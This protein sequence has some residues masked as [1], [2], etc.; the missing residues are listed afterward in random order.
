MEQ[1]SEQA[2]DERFK[3]LREV[4]RLRDDLASKAATE[5]QLQT[6]IAEY[7]RDVGVMRTLLVR[8]RGEIAALQGAL[9][10]KDKALKE[11]RR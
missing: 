6:A 3:L 10:A 8:D 5:M 11:L 7:E 1:E 9:E 2:Y 4:A